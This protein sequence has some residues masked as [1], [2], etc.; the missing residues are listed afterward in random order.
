MSRKLRALIVLL[1]GLAM[2]A[3]ACSSSVES[4]AEPE[5]TTPSDEDSTTSPDET[6]ETEDEDETENEDENEGQDETD[7]A[8]PVVSIEEMEAAWAEQRQ[9]TIDELN[10]G[11][12]GLDEDDILRGPGGYEIDLSDCPK[13]WEDEGGVVNG[14]VTIGLTLPK[15]GRLATYSSI[16][17]GFDAY[18][19]YVNENGGIGPDELNVTLIS[20]NDGYDPDKTED[21]VEELLQADDPFYI[22]TLGTPNTF[23]V[24]ETLNDECVPQ[25]FVMTPHQAWGDPENNPW[26]TGLQLSYASEAILWGTWIEQNLDAPVTVAALVMD[27]DFGL[28]YEQSFEQFVDDSDAIESVEFVRHDPEA[29]T[30]TNEMREV[31]DEEADVFISMTIGEHCLITI[32]EAGRNGIVDDSEAFF[33]PSVCKAIDPYMAP[34]GSAAEGWYVVGGG[35]KDNTD[36]QFADDPFISWMNTQLDEGGLDSQDALNATGWASNGFTHVEAMRI[37]AELDGGLT[38]TNL[39]LA[40]RAM[41]LNHPGYLDGMSFAADGNNDA[42]FIEGSDISVF[43][44]ESQTWI[45]EGDVIDVNGQ[46]SNCEWV[47]RRGCRSS[48]S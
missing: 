1:V 16:A 28:A 40:L 21:F 10:S 36:P 38:R 23:A 46:S 30:L 4:D 32:E 24:R 14:N 8:A 29:K 22:T 12:Y 35:V 42:F 13:D 37:A 25:P 41:D 17:D 11:D 2:V 15:S 9:K 39:M 6:L 33:T 20:K 43:D 18:L 44:V 48:D 19:E 5:V 26:T 3:S 31:A 27:N 45:Q 47:R 34:A 7:S